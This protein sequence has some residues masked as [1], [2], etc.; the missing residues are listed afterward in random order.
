MDDNIDLNKSFWVFAMNM[1][2]PLGGLDD[3]CGT[4]DTLESAKKFIKT[5]YDYQHI[6]IFDVNKRIYV[7]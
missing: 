4:F 6:Q 7:T 3:V 5:I 2:Y 1:C